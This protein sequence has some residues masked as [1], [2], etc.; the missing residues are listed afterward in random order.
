MASRPRFTAVVLAASRGPD[1]PVAR[2]AG[3]A[4]KVFVPIA[5]RPML[6]WVVRALRAS[7]SVARIALSIDDP[8]GLDADPELAAAV[9]EGL[10][11]LPS[12][13]SP[14]SSVAHALEA[15]DD[16]FPVLLTTADHPLLSPEMVEHFV[17]ALPEGCDIGVGV[18]RASVIRR[19]YP[20]AVRTYYRSAGGGFSGCNLYALCTPRALRAVAFW[21]RV[22]R[23]R[24]HPWRLMLTIG[25]LTALRLALGRLTPDATIACLSHVVGATARA[26]ELPFAEAAIDVDKP[27]DLTLAATILGQR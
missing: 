22:E 21:G 5:G 13:T 11:V 17:A 20:G 15:L 23:H 27:V 16:P 4:N 9:H 18:A 24:K 25:P 3:V 14:S 26:V 19:A 8:R 6:A 2:Y 1:D 12:G 10:R 7:R